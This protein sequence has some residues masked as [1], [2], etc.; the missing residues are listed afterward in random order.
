MAAQVVECPAH[1]LVHGLHAEAGLLG[2]LCSAVAMVAAGDE[3][4]S[5]HRLEQHD[6][7]FDPIELISLF[8]SFDFVSSGQS[9][10]LDRNRVS[11]SAPCRTSSTVIEQVDRNL[12]QIAF[13]AIWGC[14]TFEGGMGV[15]NEGFLHEIC[16]ILRI[17]APIE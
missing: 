17:A 11:R 16:S 2:D 10:I 14:L 1:M 7:R 4:V 15:A 13:G 5:S 8:H 6:N 3:N 9:G 12:G